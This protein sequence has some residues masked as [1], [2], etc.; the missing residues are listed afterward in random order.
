MTDYLIGTSGWSYEHWIKK[1][2]PEKLKKT[3]WIR[4]YSRHFNTAELNMS[5]YRF[6]PAKTLKAWYKKL[7][8]DFSMTFKGNRLITH[9]K[10]LHDVNDLVKKFYDICSAM[11]RKQGCFLWQLPPSMEKNEHNLE[12]LGKFL[13]VMDKRKKNAIEFRDRSWWSKEVYDMLED[14]NVGFVVVSGL[15]MPSVVKVTSDLAY[16]RFHGPGGAYSS[17]YNDKQIKSWAKKIK[18]A[19]RGCKEVYCYFNNDANAYAVDNAET[20]KKELN[21]K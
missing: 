10:K 18:K 6:P 19:G 13:D 4:F 12:K 15:D 9:R 17:K 5:F 16:F 3:E 8:G 2:Y 1:F 11:K 7:P 20:L 14:N 21:V